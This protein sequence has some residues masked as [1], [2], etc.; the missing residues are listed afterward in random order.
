MIVT[1]QRK[2][3]YRVTDILPQ[4]PYERPIIL[5]YLCPLFYRSAHDTR[6]AESTRLAILVLLL[7]ALAVSR[8]NARKSAT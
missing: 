7:R 1:W 3:H 8:S 4:V 5:K 6:T 2:V